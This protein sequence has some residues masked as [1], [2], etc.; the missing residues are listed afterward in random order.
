MHE[1]LQHFNL[2]GKSSP[3]NEHLYIESLKMAG[4]FDHANMPDSFFLGSKITFWMFALASIPPANYHR[5]GM[6]GILTI[7]RSFSQWIPWISMSM[8]VYR[9]VVAAVRGRRR[10]RSW[11][12]SRK[13]CFS[14]RCRLLM[15]VTTSGLGTQLK[16]G[17]WIH[18]DPE[19]GSVPWIPWIEFGSGSQITRSME[20]MVDGTMTSS[21]HGTPW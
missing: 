21:I 20:S 2:A 8:R 16:G 9:R 14:K 3:A 12:W 19:N 4:W 5:Y 13:R 15:L 17:G 7:C 6:I 1:K 11:E 10:W 18:H